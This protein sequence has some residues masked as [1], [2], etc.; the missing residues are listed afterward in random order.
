M[1]TAG[2]K[3]ND[4]RKKLKHLLLHLL[5]EDRIETL[6]TDDLLENKPRL[7]KNSYYLTE[8]SNQLLLIVYD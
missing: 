4:T 2:K 1:E 8:K 5:L 3:N 7:E 6:V